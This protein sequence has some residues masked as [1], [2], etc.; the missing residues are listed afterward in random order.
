MQTTVKPQAHAFNCF[1][2]KMTGRNTHYLFFCQVP[3]P[4]HC[5]FPPE[6]VHHQEWLKKQY[7]KLW[8]VTPHYILGTSS[9]RSEHSFFLN[10]PSSKE[11]SVKLV[12]RRS[13]YVFR[14]FRLTWQEIKNPTGG[15]ARFIRVQFSL[16]VHLYSWS[17]GKHSQVFKQSLST[18]TK[19][20][21][22]SK[23]CIA[24]NIFNT[25]RIW[26]CSLFAWQQPGL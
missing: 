17:M 18:H 9:L 10:S 20:Y 3:C 16:T 2:E 1:P 25:S 8:I 11:S 6:L 14:N 7:N 23:I 24:I 13:T 5:H 26:T 21:K 4:L 19:K 22:I 15:Q 12:P